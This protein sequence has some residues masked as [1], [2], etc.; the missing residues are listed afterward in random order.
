MKRRS[1]ALPTNSAGLATR[2]FAVFSKDLRLE[3][4]SR[5][6]LNT[7]L[8]FGI[9]TLA[10]VSFSLG[11]SGLPGQLLAAL[12]WIIIFFSAMA[13]LSQVFIR[14]EE[15]QTAM[16]LK[17]KADPTAVYLGK[18]FFNLVLL[19]FL[20]VIVTPLFFVLTDASTGNI[21]GFVLIAAIGVIDL[22][23]ATTLVAAII[24]KA[25]IKGALFAVL[26]FPLLILPLMMLVTA[27]TRL[28][29]GESLA[30]AAMA[31]QGLIAYAVVMITASL[32]LFK[33]VWQE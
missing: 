26:S 32:M 6:A 7:I 5:Y 30:A 16:T 12:Y 23:G 21:A 2:A 17:L 20:A 13:A 9:T 11:Q 19:T 33:F 18:L 8:M 14:E 1:T 28:L 3:T 27:S 29:N 22:C 25:A 31:L 4:R 15:A 24:S 10:V